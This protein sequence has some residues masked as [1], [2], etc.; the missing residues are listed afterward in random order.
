MSN[1]CKLKEYIIIF[2]NTLSNIFKIVVVVMTLG[3][4]FKLL[5]C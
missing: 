3:N 5:S 1:L 4:G 2:F